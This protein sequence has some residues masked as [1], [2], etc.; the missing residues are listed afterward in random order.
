M[1]Q[2]HRQRLSQPIDSIDHLKWFSK[3]RTP[4]FFKGIIEFRFNRI[5]GAQMIQKKSLLSTVFKQGR[6]YITLGDQDAV[7]LLF[8]KDIILYYLLLLLGLVIFKLNLGCSE[9]WE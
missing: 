5:L 2:G 7:I 9:Y 3:R 8:Y 6:V 1:V 4:A